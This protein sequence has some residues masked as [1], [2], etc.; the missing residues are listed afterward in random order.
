MRNSPDQLLAAIVPQAPAL[1]ALHMAHCSLAGSHTLAAL[2]QA[3]TRLRSLVLNF[4]NAAALPAGPYL[5]GLEE[6]TL[7]G[8][9]FPSLPPALVV[10]G[11]LTRLVFH[12]GSHDWQSP[13]VLSVADVDNVLA[14]LPA[15]RK[16]TTKA[17]CVPEPARERLAAALPQLQVVLINK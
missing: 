16:L 9:R 11:S 5:Q 1:T 6:L 13:L 2:A 3:T 15:L 7:L 10:A 14:H 4:C 8:N 12:N 17:R